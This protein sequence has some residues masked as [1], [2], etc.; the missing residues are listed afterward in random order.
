M[1]EAPESLKEC[2]RARFSV[3]LP[4]TPSAPLDSIMLNPSHVPKD[5]DN[6]SRYLLHHWVSI[7]A[8]VVSVAATSDRNPFLIYLTPM[9]CFSQ[10]L[11]FAV[12][13]MAASHLA[14]LAADP[15]AETI[16]R[17]HRLQAISSLRRTIQTQDPELSLAAIM[18]LQVAERL[19]TA[20]ARADHLFGARA[21]IA[22][23]PPERWKA[24]SAR[25]LLDL[26]YYHDVL[27]S[28]SRGTAP[29]LDFD[30]GD[31]SD[32]CV[33][34]R[35]LALV[36]KL[37]GHISKMHGKQVP[38]GETTADDVGNG[39]RGLGNPAEEA[40]DDVGHT[41]QAYRHAA[42]IYLLRAT[43]YGD[44]PAASSPLETSIAPHAEQCLFH[45]SQ[46]PVASP[47]VSSHTWPLWTAGCE[48]VAPQTRKF[49]RDRV[50]AMFSARLLPS[51]KRMGNDI[52]EVWLSKDAQRSRVGVDDVDCVKF[53]LDN[54]QREA[55]LV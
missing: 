34:S 42:F 32:G 18:M 7:L 38:H 12:S 27:S 16:A 15:G 24:P 45:L 31:H 50:E 54:H 21:I 2:R 6:E 14:V 23:M 4:K 30:N 36:L 25:F 19:F 1:A 22:R 35:E 40:L 37:V 49:V 53:I 13:S 29:L 11:R 17:R 47:L 41:T 43:G 39:L 5:L 33:F 10:S 8:S 44:P 26:C 52:E 3:D 9:L 55:D 51:L 48:S 46:V 20:E 28:V